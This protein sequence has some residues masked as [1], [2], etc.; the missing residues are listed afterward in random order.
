[1]PL[2]TKDTVKFF[3]YE[4]RFT[5]IYN[6]ISMIGMTAGAFILMMLLLEMW[7]VYPIPCRIATAILTTLMVAAIIYSPISHYTAQTKAIR[8]MDPDWTLADLIM[9][10]SRKFIIKA[11]LNDAFEHCK[12]S[13]TYIP[14]TVEKTMNTEDGYILVNRDEGMLGRPASKIEFH[15]KQLKGGRVLIKIS[16]G[17]GKVGIMSDEGMNLKTVDFVVRYF[18]K[19]YK[20]GFKPV[21]FKLKGEPY[22]PEWLDKVKPDVMR[23]GYM[24][25]NP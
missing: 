5:F 22:M 21:G 8:E 1:M 2:D 15:L 18:N 23:P 24:E 4:N 3:F 25:D 19:L 6:A 10:Q 9:L 13:C 7:P 20:G 17:P 16:S 11:E 14:D 12:R